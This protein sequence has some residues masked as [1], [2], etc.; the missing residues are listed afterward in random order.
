MPVTQYPRLLA[1]LLIVPII[2]SG[3][4]FGCYANILTY[5]SSSYNYT[6]WNTILAMKG[7]SSNMPKFYWKQ[8]LYYQAYTDLS[9]CSYVN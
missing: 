5:M 2:Y 4:W 8:Q 7:S 9:S 1:S 3:M 6:E